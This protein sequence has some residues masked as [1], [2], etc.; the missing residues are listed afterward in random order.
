MQGLTA[1][2]RGQLCLRWPTTR[3]S[4]PTRLPLPARRV[5]RIPLPESIWNN[6]ARMQRWTRLLAAKVAPVEVP[7][8]EVAPVEV[9]GAAEDLAAGGGGLGVV[10]GG[11]VEA[12]E[13]VAA[14]AGVAAV[15]S[16]AAASA[17]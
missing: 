2:P 10:G 8:A 16:A 1:A 15:V 11:A 13:E 7:V 17:I 4:L 9:P 3:I 6:C 5:R 12:G 14:A